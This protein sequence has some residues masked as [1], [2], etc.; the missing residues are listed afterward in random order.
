MDSCGKKRHEL[1][2]I[3]PFVIIQ[4]NIRPIC[5]KE[6]PRTSLHDMLILCSIPGLY[7]AILS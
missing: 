3:L 6:K 1:I 7:E 5:L 2:E 4:R